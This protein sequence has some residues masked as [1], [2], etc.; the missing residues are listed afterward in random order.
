MYVEWGS[1]IPTALE[2]RRAMRLSFGDL[3]GAW[4]ADE[5]MIAR[6]DVSSL[7]RMRKRVGRGVGK[8]A[9]SKS[10]QV[11]VGECNERR[12]DGNKERE[13]KQC[14]AVLP[15]F[16]PHSL[17]TETSQWRL[18]PPLFAGTNHSFAI[19]YICF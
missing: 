5:L 9:R 4:V 11:W 7:V 3:T 10:N 12:K 15:F 1:L 6:C 17:E 14:G 16:G 18:P 2:P 19:F 13:T 8:W